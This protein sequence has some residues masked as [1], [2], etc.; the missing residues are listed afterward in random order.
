MTPLARQSCRSD[1]LGEAEPSL[2]PLCLAIA[3][4]C[5]TA[6]S[7]AWKLER[8]HVMG[9]AAEPSRWEVAVRRAEDGVDAGIRFFCSCVGAARSDDGA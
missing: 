1:Q 9:E 2:P 7:K 3:T 6:C 8:L 5:V 4:T